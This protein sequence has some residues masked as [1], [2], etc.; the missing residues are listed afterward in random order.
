MRSL[1][2]TAGVRTKPTGA[3]EEEAPQN[4]GNHRQRGET[5][6]R[7]EEGSHLR[8][9]LLPTPEI[10]ISSKYDCTDC[11]VAISGHIVADVKLNLVAV[12]YF[13]SLIFP[14]PLRMRR[15]C[16]QQ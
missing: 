9:L 12:A 8:H 13:F 11:T 14:F 1:E 5:H 15:S 3:A 7:A 2:C 16:C 6:S 10:L 4:G